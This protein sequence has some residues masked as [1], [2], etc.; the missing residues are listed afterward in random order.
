MRCLGAILTVLALL[1]VQAPWEMCACEGGTVTPQ[2]FGLVG[3]DL[4]CACEEGHAHDLH[5]H[6]HHGHHRDAH[7]PHAHHPHP[8]H[9]HGHPHHGHERDCPQHPDHEHDHVTFHMAL[10]LM[11]PAV[12]L[13]AADIAFAP[14]ALLTASHEA[15]AHDDAETVRDDRPPGDPV[16]PSVRTERLLL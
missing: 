14:L 8:H 11:P 2:L 9:Q 7:H 5:G 15:A 3:H 10:G 1:A 13:D 6:H 16:A 4:P 12:E